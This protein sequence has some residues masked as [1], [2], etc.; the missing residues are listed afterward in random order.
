[1]KRK[2][3]KFEVHS[4]DE[5]YVWLGRGSLVIWTMEKFLKYINS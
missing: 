1:M 3:L 4:D 5:V 2:I